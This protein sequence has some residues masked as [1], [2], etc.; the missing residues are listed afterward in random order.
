MASKDLKARALFY[1][2]EHP[3]LVERGRLDLSAAAGADHLAG[4]PPREHVPGDSD[5]DQSI[6]R[7][8]LI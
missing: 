7:L 6:L 5:I 4:L 2:D 8:I 3:E 1:L